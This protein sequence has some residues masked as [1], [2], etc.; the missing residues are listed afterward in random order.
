M[1]I[2]AKACWQQAIVILTSSVMTKQRSLQHKSLSQSEPPLH[3]LTSPDTLTVAQGGLRQNPK[4]T[5]VTELTP[6]FELCKDSAE[7]RLIN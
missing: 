3:A 6:S 2:N 7:I 1:N 5:W 4:S